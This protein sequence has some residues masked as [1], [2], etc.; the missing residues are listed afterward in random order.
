M[1]ELPSQ[2][3]DRRALPLVVRDRLLEQIRDGQLRPGAQIPP[4]PALCEAFGVSRSTV[5]EAIKLLERDG[6]IDVQH[7]RGSFVTGMAQLGRERPVT[8]FESVTEMMRRLGYT[9]ENRVLDVQERHPTEEEATELGLGTD[10]LVVHLERLRLHEGQPFVLSVNV[11]ARA[12]F[13]GP[14][15]DVDWGASM[16]DLLDERGRVVVASSAHLRATPAPQSLLAAG[17]D[18]PGDP[19]LLISETCVTAA[20]EPVLLAHDYH[21]GDAFT[22]HAVRRRFPD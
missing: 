8:R 16:I 18:S 14:L 5:R 12:V 19:W 22:F 10:E 7:G 15:E 20:G 4:E 13:A 11:V 3:I 6:V 2:M 9:V 21:R 1:S 17:L